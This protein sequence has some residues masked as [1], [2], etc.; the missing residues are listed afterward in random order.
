M[1]TLVR[2]NGPDAQRGLMRPFFQD[3]FDV[4]NF[5]GR[6]LF[7]GSKSLPAVNIS[8]DDKAYHIDVVSP[9]FKKEDFKVN[10][11]NNVLTISAETKQETTN[12]NE[13]NQEGNQQ[14]NN[15]Q[16]SRREYSYSSFTR[17]FQLPENV[18]EDEIDASYTDGIL[19]LQIPKAEQQPKTSKEISIK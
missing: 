6:D 9:G 2:R 14:G 18:K 17:S 13:G 3:F 4:E 1:S 12:N 7:Q 11:E 15:R 19:K 5:F 8:E 16:Y 10:V